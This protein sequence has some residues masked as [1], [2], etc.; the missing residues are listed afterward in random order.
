MGSNQTGVFNAF[1]I[2]VDGGKPVQLTDSK[3]SAIQPIG[4]FPEDER[5]LYSSDQGGNEQNHL[6]VQSPDGNVR[7]LTPG[8]KLKAD[9]LGWT[10]DE[11]SFFFVTNERDPSVFD[12]YEMAVNGYERSSS[13]PMR[14]GSFRRGLAGP[15]L[16]R[17]RKVPVLHGQRR[18]PPR[19]DGGE[20]GAPHSR[21]CVRG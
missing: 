19:P 2:P 1:A 9:F 8:D 5:F 4:Y 20:D 15:P 16:G 13:T 11:K 10:P 17:P 18:L 21:R 7:D 6:Y 3:V 14:E 12:V